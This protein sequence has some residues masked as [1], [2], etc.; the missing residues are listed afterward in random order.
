MQLLALLRY[1]HYII[2]SLQSSAIGKK[3]HSTCKLLKEKLYLLQ[4]TSTAVGTPL[5]ILA[6]HL[7]VDLKAT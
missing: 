4:A 2:R 7:Q 5:D 3:G 6:I 1:F